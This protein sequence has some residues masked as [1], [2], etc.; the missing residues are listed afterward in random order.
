MAR[1]LLAVIVLCAVASY[2]S[3][4]PV[5]ISVDMTGEK[6]PF[7]NGTLGNGSLGSH[8]TGTVTLDPDNDTIS[9]LLNTTTIQGSS[10][11]GFHI[12]GPIPVAATTTTN[13]GVYRDSPTPGTNP[14]T[15]QTLSGTIDLAFD[16]DLGNKIDNILGNL[17]GA[18]I[19]L[20]TNTFPGGAVRSQLPE[21][22]TLTLLACGAMGLLMRRRKI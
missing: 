21:P 5:V 9:W 12:H 4:A 3:A 20:H 19:N 10:F 18:Y 22:T 2:A 16:S 1:A 11:T 14:G 13:V 15:P 7:A 8:A 17:N 6:E